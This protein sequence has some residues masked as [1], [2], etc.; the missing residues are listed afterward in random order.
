MRNTSGVPKNVEGGRHFETGFRGCPRTSRCCAATVASRLLGWRS[1]Y[2]KLLMLKAV[3]L[4]EGVGPPLVLLSKDVIICLQSDIKS[5]VRPIPTCLPGQGG[6]AKLRCGP[7]QGNEAGQ[8][9]HFDSTSFESTHRFGL[10]AIEENDQGEFV[11]SLPPLTP[12]R[13]RLKGEIDELQLRELSMPE[14]L[15][16]E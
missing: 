1:A 7:C 6:D 3:Y 15:A 12:G 10:P 11:S 4:I 16:G 13:M 14:Q 8:A 9:L 5:W 2:A